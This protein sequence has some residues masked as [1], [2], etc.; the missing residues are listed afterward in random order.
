MP[1]PTEDVP[2]DPPTGQGDRRFNLWALC[3][4]VSGTARVGAVVELADEMDGTVEG[5]EV[6]VAMIA[7]IHR[8]SAGGAVAIDDVLHPEGEVGILR[9]EVRHE[10]S[11]PVVRQ[12]RY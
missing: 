11:P 4:G 7:D 1:D 3:P 5:V 2:G 6:A 10:A 12:P 9:P 8:A